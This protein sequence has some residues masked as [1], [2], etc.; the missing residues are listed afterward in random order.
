[1]NLDKR[2][3]KSTAILVLA[4]FVWST[5]GGNAWA[6]TQA[7]RRDPAGALLRLV[8]DPRLALTKTEKE[9]LRRYVYRTE[10]Q[11]HAQPVAVSVRAASFDEDE[12]AV[13][14]MQ[15]IAAELEQIVGPGKDRPEK[16]NQIEK[17]LEVIH[18]RVLRKAGETKAHLTPAKRE[19]HDVAQARYG[20]L[21]GGGLIDCIRELVPTW[22]R[23]LE[24]VLFLVLILLIIMLILGALASAP[25]W[26]PVGAAILFFLLLFRG[27]SPSSPVAIPA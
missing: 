17:R 26:A 4:S 6:E 12:G 7:A 2:R 18:L 14:E 27:V 24:L 1:M 15:Q 5:S 10:T 11:V 9:Y 8:D 3:F 25:V 22:E 13:V 19:R 16:L 20:G 23:V 21:N